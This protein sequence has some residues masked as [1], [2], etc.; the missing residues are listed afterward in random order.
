MKVI[1]GNF[2][3]CRFIDNMN[4]DY[5][6]PSLENKSWDLC[7]TDPPYNLNFK[8]KTIS[9]YIWDTSYR[10]NKI[11]Y[12]DDSIDYLKWC[13]LLFNEIQLKSKGQIITCGMKNLYWW[14]QN[15]TPNYELKGWVKPN[16][17]CFRNYEPIL[18]YGKISNMNLWG[19][20]VWI[21]NLPKLEKDLIHPCPKIL[22]FWKQIPI[23]LKPISVI[24][25]FLGSGTTSEICE[26]LGIPW[27]GYEI[28][29]EYA[30]DIEKRIKRG[31]QKHKNFV[32][33]KKTTQTKLL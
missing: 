10:K 15:Q 19:T 11:Y 23:K 14:I 28:M 16:D 24:D 7:L 22:D 9:K 4:S 13:K 8:G 32:N 30:P 27:L 20:P 1:K 25:P 26:H 6:L 31:I 21:I 5:G 3:E 17:V 2:G 18:L 33:I 29:E 12:S